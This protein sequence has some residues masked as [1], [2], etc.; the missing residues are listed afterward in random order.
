MFQTFFYQPMLNLLVFLYDIIPGHDLGVVIIVLAI[1]IRLALYPLTKSMLK[2]QKALQELQ[3]KI[4]EIQKKY[5]KKE[6][7][8]KA[9]LEL[10]KNNKVNPFSSCL[11]LIIQMPFLIAIFQVL[12][13]GFGNGTLDLVYSFVSRPDSINHISFGV[14]DLSAPHNVALA[15][16]AG[17][18]QFWQSKM[19]LAK[20]PEIKADESRDEDM[21]AIMNKQM[22]YMFPLLT[23]WF[24]YSFPSGLA[25]YWLMTTLATVAQQ[26][27]IFKK[28]PEEEVV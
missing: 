2:S 21:T 14:F 12:R 11:P 25:L 18:A 6:D 27:M 7:Q 28:S 24:S 22:T 17:L 19:M 13:N 10:Y 4:K 9:M 26:K 20:R 16:L 15:I 23:I 8:S 3:P 5:P 1:L